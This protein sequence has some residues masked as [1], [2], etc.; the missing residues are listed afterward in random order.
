MSN[1][2]CAVCWQISYED[3]KNKCKNCNSSN[4]GRCRQCGELNVKYNWLALKKLNDAQTI[5]KDFIDELKAHTGNY[6]HSI[7]HI[8]GLTRDSNTKEYALVMSYYPGGDWR[9][10]I[11]DKGSPLLWEDKLV[12]EL[13][14]SC[15]HKD[16]SKRPSCREI[17]KTT[18]ILH[19]TLKY[20]YE[21]IEYYESFKKADE[22]IE[23]TQEMKTAKIMINRRRQQDNRDEE[24]MLE[25]SDSD[26]VTDD[27]N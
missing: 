15:C 22:E 25:W 16:P 2:L 12:E 18:Y 4:Y 26:L 3:Y 20:E 24:E 14:K 21:N 5:S 13:I 27:Y 6:S 17:V 9:K 7:A 1:K 23:K 10:V 8:Y 19:S 11:R